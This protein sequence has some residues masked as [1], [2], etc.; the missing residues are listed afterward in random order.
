LFGSENITKLYLNLVVMN[1]SVKPGSR[2]P[3]VG[4]R[5]RSGYWGNTSILKTA[6]EAEEV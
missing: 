2:M 5:S 1:P 6:Q 3:G 4:I